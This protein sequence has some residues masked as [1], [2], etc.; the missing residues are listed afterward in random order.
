MNYTTAST[1][2]EAG[3]DCSYPNVPREGGE[4]HGHP[5]WEVVS[6]AN[7]NSLD[8]TSTH[9][10]WGW[11]YWSERGPRRDLTGSPVRLSDHITINMWTQIFNSFPR[12]LPCS[13]YN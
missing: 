2:P 5:L 13:S 7:S 3:A 12:L 10:R 8:A 1:Y 11:E 9:G 6:L 4:V